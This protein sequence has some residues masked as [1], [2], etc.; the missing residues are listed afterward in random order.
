MGRNFDQSVRN[1]L[2]VLDLGCGQGASTWFLARE[3]FKVCSVDGS[4]SALEK[5]SVRMAKEH[6][7]FEGSVCCF[8]KLPFFSNSFD[9]VVDVVSSVHNSM[10]D[11]FIIFDE[12]SRVLKPGGKL[13]S[14]MP[15][16]CTAKQAYQDAPTTFLRQRDVHQLLKRDFSSINILLST[17]QLDQNCTIENWIVTADRLGGVA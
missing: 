11:L 13:F 5:T 1:E 17:Y 15:T 2:K 12:V 3:G 16:V 9:V 8:T 10:A 14:V 6:L 7:P 4:I